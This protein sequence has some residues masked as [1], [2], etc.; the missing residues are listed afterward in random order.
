M[1]QYLN[2]QCVYVYTPLLSYQLLEVLDIQQ[3]VQ[4]VIYTIII[5]LGWHGTNTRNYRYQ[6]SIVM[7]N[8]YT[9]VWIVVYSFLKQQHYNVLQGRVICV[10]YN[11]VC[12]PLYFRSQ[13]TLSQWVL[14]VNIQGNV[15]WVHVINWP[16]SWWIRNTYW[17]S[18]FNIW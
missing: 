13:D 12:K 18:S 11:A 8:I 10:S 15:L 7:I 5:Y 3:C 6:T 9:G 2:V 4:E 14:Y 16:S 17:M 1:F